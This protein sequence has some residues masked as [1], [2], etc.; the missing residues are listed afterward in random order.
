MPDVIRKIYGVVL[1]TVV[2]A[3][4]IISFIVDNIVFNDF[5][6]LLGFG[7][8]GPWPSKKAEHIGL[9]I[10]ARTN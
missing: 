6:A 8:F 1:I 10:H 2:V 5:S 4:V 7:S 3:I 9:S